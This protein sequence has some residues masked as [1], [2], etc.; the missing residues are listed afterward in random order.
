MLFTL[1]KL[2]NSKR[3]SKQE[4][5]AKFVGIIMNHFANQTNVLA[6]KKRFQLLLQLG[7]W[8]FSSPK[9][10]KYIVLSVA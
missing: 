6:L 9:Y 3:L 7:G 4:N 8:N 1:G 10:I 2:I 5:L